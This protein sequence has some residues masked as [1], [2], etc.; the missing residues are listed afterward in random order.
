MFYM[1]KGNMSWLKIEFGLERRSDKVAKRKLV[2]ERVVRE[3]AHVL[4]LPFV[5]TFW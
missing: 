3:C 4:D 2:R 5:L 1:E